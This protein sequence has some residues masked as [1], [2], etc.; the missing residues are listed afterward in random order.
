MHRHKVVVFGAGGVGKSA[1]ITRFVKGNFL[2]NYDPTIEEVY[3][4]TSQI[5]GTTFSLEILDTAGADQF[6]APQERYIKS[7][8]GFILVFSLTQ[9]TSLREIEDL[10][11]RIYHL[12]GDNRP[13]PLVVVGTKLD[14]TTEREVPQELIRRYA[15]R[16]GVPFYETSAKRNWNVRPSFED[17]VRQMRTR[18]PYPTKIKSRR[19]PFRRA[20]TNKTFTDSPGPN[21][22]KCL[23]M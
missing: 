16:W 15:V 11:Q 14:L 18:F 17:L 20:K 10:R 13:I 6:C 2:S 19:G 23:I 21:P 3:E 4:C 7:A 9:E 1:L 22:D 12:R 5:D 8:H